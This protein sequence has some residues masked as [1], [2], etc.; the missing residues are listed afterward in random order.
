MIRGVW[1]GGSRWTEKPALSERKGISSANE[2]L[3]LDSQNCSAFDKIFWLLHFHF[4]QVWVDY[5]PC[6]LWSFL[7][8]F[9]EA[10]WYAY[11]GVKLPTLSVPGSSKF[12]KSASWYCYRSE[13]LLG[14]H[15]ADPLVFV[16]QVIVLFLCDIVLQAL[17][18]TFLEIAFR[19]FSLCCQ[20]VPFPWLI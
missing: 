7:F 16:H 3:H 4:C 6:C 18:Y 20:A 5:S 2:C 12:E 15:F 10:S 17:Y 1:E 14:S 9:Y 8:P 19:E 11:G 13:V